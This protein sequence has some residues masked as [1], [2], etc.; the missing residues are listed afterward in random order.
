MLQLVEV[1][2]ILY[3]CYMNGFTHKREKAAAWI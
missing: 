3:L 1:V 2:K